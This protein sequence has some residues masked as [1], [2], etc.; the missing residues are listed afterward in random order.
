[1]SA[2]GRPPGRR[3]VRPLADLVS[4]L[5][6]PILAK[7]AG[8]SS[9]LVSAWPEIAGTRLAETTRPEKLIWAARRSDLDPFEPA[10]LVVACEGASALR[11][12]HET[13]ELLQRIDLFFGYHA[14]GRLKIVQRAA[15]A[16]APSRKPKLAPLGPGEKRVIGK[17][18]ERIESE[19]LKVALERFGETVLGRNRAGRTEAD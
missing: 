8:L 1:M 5:V 12:Q 9:A 15:P 4:G 6:D 13:S 18:T 11:L 17:A 2:S 10:T 19:R 3:Q 7:K 16:T 14:V